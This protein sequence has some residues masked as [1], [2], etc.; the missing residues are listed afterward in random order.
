M[1]QDQTCHSGRPGPGHIALDGD[2]TPPKK[3]QLSPL[4]FHPMYVEKGATRSPQFSAN[5]CCGQMAGHTV[6]RRPRPRRHILLDVDPARLKG[7][8]SSPAFWPMS[9]VAKR[10]P[11]SATA[12][13]LLVHHAHDQSFWIGPRMQQLVLPEKHQFQMTAILIF[14]DSK[15]SGRLREWI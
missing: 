12:E 5:V 2:P 9:I 11:I 10:S 6:R 7:G 1:D 8:H 14:L 15:Q 13:L 3:A 4:N